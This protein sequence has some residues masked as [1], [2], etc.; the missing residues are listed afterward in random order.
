[1]PKSI[2]NAIVAQFR[3]ECIQ[4]PFQRQQ[5]HASQRRLALPDA[6]SNKKLRSLQDA[7]EH[8]QRYSGSVQIGMYSG[9]FSETAAARFPKET[10][11]SRCSFKQKVKVSSRCQRASTTL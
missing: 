3:S 11:A 1:M 6:V 4:E 5:Q 8:R 10:C 9:T 7:K 2:D